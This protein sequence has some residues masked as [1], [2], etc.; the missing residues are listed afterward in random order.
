MARETFSARDLIGFAVF[1]VG[2][3]LIHE[4]I[5]RPVAFVVWPI[6][7]LVALVTLTFGVRPLTAT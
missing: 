5:G 7:F 3:V 4:H 2:F 6:V 1:A